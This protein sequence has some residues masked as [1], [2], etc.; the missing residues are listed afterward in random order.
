MALVTVAPTTPMRVVVT[1]L[2]VV[3]SITFGLYALDKFRARRSQYRV[4]ERQLLLFSLLGGWPGAI[5]AQRYFRHKTQKLSFRIRFYSCVLVNVGV[6]LFLA[7][8]V[9]L[10]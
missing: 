5:L 3:N 7:K 4:P 2:V 10:R 1:M 8:S 9:Y 6:C